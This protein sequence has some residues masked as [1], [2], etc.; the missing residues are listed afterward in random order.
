MLL[1]KFPK[2]SVVLLDL[3]KMRG[4]G[5]GRCLVSAARAALAARAARALRAVAVTLH[6]L[7]LVFFERACGLFCIYSRNDVGSL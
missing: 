7:R 5:G 2:P 1:S 3:E 6:D 4:M